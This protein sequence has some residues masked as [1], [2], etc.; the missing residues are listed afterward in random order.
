[1]VKAAIFGSGNGSN[2][3]AIMQANVEGLEVACV[4]CDQK[5]A[6]IQTRG[7]NFGLPV[8]V[9]LRETFA[10]KADFEAE[11]VKLLEQYQVELILLAGYMRILSPAF[12]ARY[13]NRILNIHPSLL[14]AYPGRNALENAIQAKESVVGCSVH[15]VD[16][17]IDSGALIA[18]KTVVIEPK[19][20]LEQ[21]RAAVHRAEHELYPATIQ[22]II[23]EMENRQ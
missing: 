7:H 3:E 13:R 11:M 21:V 8:H 16:E 2:F 6:F 10:S 20:Q 17:G 22:S 14:P 19:W 12:V 15:Y 4:I 1:M 23:K 5:E 9:V 18:Q